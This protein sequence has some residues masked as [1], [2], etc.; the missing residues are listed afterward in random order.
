MQPDYQLKQHL[1][2]LI[3]KQFYKSKTS[4]HF[5]N[6]STSIAWQMGHNSRKGFFLWQ[7]LLLDFAAWLDLTLNADDYSISAAFGFSE[8]ILIL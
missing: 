8:H 3:S 7:E 4:S 5:S 1:Q 2:N 6:F